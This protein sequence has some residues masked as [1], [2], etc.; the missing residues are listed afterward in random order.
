MFSK[1]DLKNKL[2]DLTLYVRY[3]YLE[4]PYWDA[5]IHHY[6]S[7]GVRNINVIIRDKNDLKGFNNFYYHKDLLI[8]IHFADKSIAPN[9]TWKIIDFK[10][11]KKNTSYALILDVDEFLYFLNPYSTLDSIMGKTKIIRVPWLMNPIPYKNSLNSGFFGPLYKEL[12][13]FEVL[14]SIKSCH[15]FQRKGIRNFYNFN[16]QYGNRQI[17]GKKEIYSYKNGLVLVHNWARS[18]NDSL[19]KT[20]FSEIKNVKTNDSNLAVEKIKKGQL[21]IRSRYL[22][23]LDNQVKY[24]QNLDTG[25]RTK[26]NF[27]KELELLTRYFRDKDLVQFYKS[28]SNFDEKIKKVVHKLPIFPIDSIT[29]QINYLEENSYFLK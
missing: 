13:K 7:L 20:I 29:Q 15:Q 22:A 27:D 17:I 5:F 1:V 18:L 14:K 6:Y 19:I 2:S 8:K 23:Y 9:D 11:E 10:K 16:L 25:Y 26:F 24:L 3:C 4:E 12:G 28:Y 21:T